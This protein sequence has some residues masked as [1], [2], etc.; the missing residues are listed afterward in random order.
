MKKYFLVIDQGT[1][2]SRIVLY[3]KKFEIFDIVQKEFKQYFPNEG[4]VEHNATEIWD[5][6]RNLISKILRKNKL[7]SKN[8][9]SI[10]I[11]NQR[12]TTVLWNK[13]TG[14]PVYRAIVWQDRRTANLCEKLKRKGIDKKIQKITGLELDPYFSATKIK[15][16]IDN[17][18]EVNKNLKNNNLLFG[19]ID[20]WLL[21]KL[22]KGKSHL[23]DIS[24]ASRTM[25]FDS[26]KRAVV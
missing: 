5:D 7:N 19:T 11:T 6:V 15:W 18:K 22:T 26:Q 1:T 4:W 23:T 10:G 9:I 3:S 20:T 24:N 17:V 8:I 14:K 2:S 16:I 25:I 13:K 21:W 12:E